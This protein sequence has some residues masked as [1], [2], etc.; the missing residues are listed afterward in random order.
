M[1]TIFNDPILNVHIFNK[2]TSNKKHVQLIIAY[3]IMS[4][5]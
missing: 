4:K 5:S 2:L 1:L 3:H